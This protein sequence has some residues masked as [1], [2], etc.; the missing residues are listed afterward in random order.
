M[1]TAQIPVPVPLHTAGGAFVI[2]R[3]AP[4]EDAER[5]G[6][7]P[8]TGAHDRNPNLRA[9]F[10]SARAVV[11]ST[12]APTSAKPAAAASNRAVHTPSDVLS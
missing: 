1:A 6:D 8:R 9:A 4:G 2:D 7:A 11:D 12:I 5:I 3:F 10:S